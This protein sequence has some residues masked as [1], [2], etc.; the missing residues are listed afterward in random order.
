M[1]R[2]PEWTLL[3]GYVN[4]QQL[5]KKRISIRG[6]QEN[7]GLNH[8]RCHLASVRVAIFKDKNKECPGGGEKEP[9]TVLTEQKYPM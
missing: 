2:T 4:V 6:H 9:Y 7:A 3:K 1:D 5:Y 8:M